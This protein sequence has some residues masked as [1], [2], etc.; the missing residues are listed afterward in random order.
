MVLVLVLIVVVM[1]VVVVVVVCAQP[2]STL[3]TSIDRWVKY[4]SNR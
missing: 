1:A 3:K 2:S 4:D